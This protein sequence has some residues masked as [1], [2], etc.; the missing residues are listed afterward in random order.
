M[1]VKVEGAGNVATSTISSAATA[2][3]TTIQ[4]DTRWMAP[5][6]FADAAEAGDAEEA[7][8]RDPR[9]LDTGQGTTAVE[10]R[11]LSV[12]DT[13]PGIEWFPPNP[14]PQPP[15]V[16]LDIRHLRAPDG[17]P[18][19]YE[20]HRPEQTV[21]YRLV[22]QHAATFFEQAESAAGATLPQFVKDEFD[23]FL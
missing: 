6:L 15:H 5:W 14:K 10:E 20:R 11:E 9:A 3:N 13:A 1:R 8:T 2:A 23:A 12:A 19:H 18:V 21:L 17:T 16:S 4:R 7:G 22:Q